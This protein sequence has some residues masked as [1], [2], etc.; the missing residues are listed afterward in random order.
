VCIEGFPLVQREQELYGGLLQVVL[1]D[2]DEGD[3][4]LASMFGSKPATLL[5][6]MGID[7]PNYF[8]PGG[9]NGSTRL[10]NIRGYST[11]VVDR[12]GIVRGVDLFGDA[13]TR[14]IDTVMKEWADER[15][16]EAGRKGGSGG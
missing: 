8:I 14:C 1:V 13:L 5:E 9:F 10:F 11:L 16:R 15:V 6:G 7:W 12:H 3:G 4:P 2:V